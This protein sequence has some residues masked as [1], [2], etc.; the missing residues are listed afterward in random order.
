MLSIGGKVQVNSINRVITK[1]SEL[2]AV[3]FQLTSMDLLDNPNVTDEGLVSCEGCEQIA[4]LNVTGTPISNAGLENLKNGRKLKEPDIR[5]QKLV[6][7][8]GLAH[9]KNCKKLTHLQLGGTRITKDGLAQLKDCSLT[10]LWV[11]DTP[12]T[13]ESVQVISEFLKLRSLTVNGTKI[14]DNGVKKLA[15]ALPRCDIGWTGGVIE[16]K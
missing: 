9:L 5:R 13:D 16:R 2:P 15:A 12:L 11:N 7:D 4:M 8:A 3:P 1:T 6:T 14:T 10:T